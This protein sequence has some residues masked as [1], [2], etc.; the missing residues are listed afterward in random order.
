MGSFPREI[1]PM[2]ALKKYMRRERRRYP[3]HSICTD[4][5]F[6]VWD[7]L[8][9][10]PRTDKVG[11]CL[12]A[13]SVKGACLQTRQLQMGSHHLF[14][15]NDPGG[16][17]VVMIEVPAS[18]GEPPWKIQARIVSYDKHPERR[19]YPFDVRLQFENPTPAEIKNIEQFIKSNSSQKSE[20][21]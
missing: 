1:Q 19:K 14:L 11:G 10:R 3:R 7:T 9:R 18:S 17:T 8:T 16:R 15:D 21:K 20:E 6:F 4:V 2:K 12:T 13:V 5:D